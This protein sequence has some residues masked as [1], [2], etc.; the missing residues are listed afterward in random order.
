MEFRGTIQQVIH[1]SQPDEKPS[2]FQGES[3]IEGWPLS[4]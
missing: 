4:D 3:L 1:L 2:L